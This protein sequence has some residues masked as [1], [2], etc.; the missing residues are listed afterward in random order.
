VLSRNLLIGGRNTS[1][2]QG[3]FQIERALAADV[4][5]SH[6]GPVELQS[7]FLERI[8]A[9]LEGILLRCSGGTEGAD[10]RKQVRIM[11]RGNDLSRKPIACFPTRHIAPSR[12]YPWALPNRAAERKSFCVPKGAIA[13]FKTR[14]FD[15]IGNLDLE[16]TGALSGT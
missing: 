7:I 11:I 3:S 2:F 13:G 10:I 15:R 6:A 8:E 9:G 16:P 5:V 1:R 14:D 4:H 12:A